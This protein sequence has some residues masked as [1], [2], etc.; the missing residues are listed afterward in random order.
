MDIQRPRG[1]A[2]LLPEA[3]GLWSA[4]ERVALREFE[5]ANYR[6]IRTP[7]FEHTELFVRGVGDTTD[8]VE[9]EMYSFQDR[10][11]RSLTLRPEGTAGVV[12]A[13]VENKRYG[14]ADIDKLYYLGPM[15]RYERPQSGRS[16]QFHQYGCEVF[17]AE[18]P[19]LD[20]EVIA[21]S[22]R[23]LSEFGLTGLTVEVNSVGCDVCRPQHKAAMLRLVQPHAEEFCGDCQRR[24]ER[25]P[26]RMFDCKHETCQRLLTELQVP[27]ISDVLCAD[28]REHL[29]AVLHHTA[30][31]GIPCERNPNLVRGLD[32]YTRTA[33]EVTVAGHSTVSGGG[34]YNSL[35]AELGGPET[36]GIGFAG[37]VER[38]V[39]L[40]IDQSLRAGED[41][42]LD[43]YVVT[44][45]QT[46]TDQATSL[47]DTLRRAGFMADRDFQRRSVKSQVKSA[48]RQHARWMAV[49]GETELA[50]G[51][52]TVK[53]MDSGEQEIWPFLEVAERM[54]ER[55]TKQEG[56]GK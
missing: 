28:C 38:A 56:E 50:N 4:F 37:G 6:E 17:G 26:L 33:W 53:D 12:R 47:V 14:R 16:R 30:L 29:E 35:V 54:K 8:I 51:T 41:E 11:G 40:A 39:Q 10:G 25:N 20:A 43:V 7:L 1:T 44:A 22:Y 19:E 49:L 21:L 36:P 9:K 46:A 55:R 52:V 13:Y 31:L 2:D 45:D 32:Y 42:R 3:L 15:F 48:D 5:R 24:M 27:R 23:I 34:R 18:A